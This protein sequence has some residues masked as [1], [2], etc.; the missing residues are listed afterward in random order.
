MTEAISS[1]LNFMDAPVDHLLAQLLELAGDRAVVHGV[2]DAQHDAADQRRID[3]RVS[4]M[5]RRQERRG[6]RGGDPFSTCFGSIAAAV[7][8][9]TRTS[10]CD[11]S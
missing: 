7:V 4:R 2:A 1:A 11:S 9:R 10:P 8:R 3:D 6:Q 5:G